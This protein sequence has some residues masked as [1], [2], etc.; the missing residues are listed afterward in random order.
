MAAP[1]RV[2]QIE[3]NLADARLIRELV[4][5][6]SS[7]GFTWENVERLNAASDILRVQPFDLVLLDLS[8]PDSQ[9][10]ETFNRLQPHALCLPIV[11]LT[12]LDNELVGTQAV[13]AGAQ[14]YLVKG[15]LDGERLVRVLRYAIERKHS[16]NALRA[17]IEQHSANPSPK[18]L[19]ALTKINPKLEIVRK[20][21]SHR[22]FV[23]LELIAEGVTNREIAKYLSISVRTVERSRAA[24]MRK[25]GLQNRAELIDF[26]LRQRTLSQDDKEGGRDEQ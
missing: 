4:T 5:E 13:R 19:T 6:A 16:E 24:M 15:Q 23:M 20:N 22:E 8:L 12:G 11:V 2:L 9:G 21:L 25:F 26:A 3:D 18:F 1:I 17:G 7:V 10:L 14:D